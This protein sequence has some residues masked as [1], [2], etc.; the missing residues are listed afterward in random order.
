[1]FDSLAAGRVVQLV[2]RGKQQDI[3]IGV[4][5]IKAYNRRLALPLGLLANKSAEQL[6]QV[7]L[8]VARDVHQITTDHP[9]VS[10]T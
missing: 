2:H 10:A 7:L 5:P 3:R 1:M 8:A 4:A 9:L 6:R